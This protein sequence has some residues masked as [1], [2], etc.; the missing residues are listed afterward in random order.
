MQY[1]KKASRTGQTKFKVLA[2]IKL[3]YINN[4]LHIHTQSY[5]MKYIQY[6]IRA[7]RKRTNK[8]I[9]IKHKRK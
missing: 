6:H 5:M 9:K 2:A 4:L 1:R 7:D 3:T 8:Y